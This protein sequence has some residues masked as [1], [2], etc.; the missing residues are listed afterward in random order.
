M[1][2]MPLLFATVLGTLLLIVGIAVMF[3]QPKAADVNP[4]VL[5]KDVVLVKGPEQAKVTVAV[6]SDF[7]C[8]A[9]KAAEP[10]LQQVGTTYPD[11]V[12]MVFHHFP[13]TAIHHY[14]MLAAQAAQVAQEQGKFWEFHDKL[15]ETQETWSALKTEAEVLEKFTEFAV[16]LGIDK[17]VFQERIQTDQVKQYIANDIALGNSL[18]VNATPTIYI[19]GQKVNNAALP[20]LMS[21]VESLLK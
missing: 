14:A 16:E 7:Q 18:S 15:F 13:L 4:D 11:K 9:C 6:F 19:N 8:P 20:Q 1:K 10:L 3:S 5:T 2:N 12:K 17:Q 21:T